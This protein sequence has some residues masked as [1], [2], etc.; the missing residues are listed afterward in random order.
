MELI[1]VLRLAGARERSRLRKQGKK[2]NKRSQRLHSKRR[3]M[4]Y[5]KNWEKRRA[6]VQAIA[7]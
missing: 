6:M 4:A 5:R 7:T 2:S 3:R 1:P